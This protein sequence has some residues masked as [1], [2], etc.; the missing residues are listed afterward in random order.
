MTL[1]EMEDQCRATTGGQWV[2][3]GGRWVVGGGWWVAGGGGQWVVG[4]RW[5]WAVG[6]RW[7]VVGGEHWSTVPCACADP[8]VTGGTEG[9]VEQESPVKAGSKRRLLGELSSVGLLL[10][11]RRSTR[12][13]HCGCVVLQWVDAGVSVLVVCCVS[14]QLP[15]CP[16][17]VQA[18]R[19]S[20]EAVFMCDCLK[21]LLPATQQW[22]HHGQGVKGRRGCGDTANPFCL[23]PLQFSF[24][25]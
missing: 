21:Q 24:E 15:S 22:V 20:A 23:R 14:M 17:K 25:R 10:P 3:G 5:W 13:G 18:Q 9:I 11:K 6:G 12:V 4:G 19:R 1:S 8:V 2:A 16:T 7:W